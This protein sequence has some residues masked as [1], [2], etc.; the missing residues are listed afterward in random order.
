M[1]ACWL[2]DTCRRCM[3]ETRSVEEPVTRSAPVLQTKPISAVQ[4]AGAGYS[5]PVRLA[6]P[7]G[8]P[9]SPRSPRD[10]DTASCA[11]SVIDALADTSVYDTSAA[12]TPAVP[13]FCP[14][15]RPTSS[16]PEPPPEPAAAAAA[17]APAGAS[18][19]AP[20]RTAEAPSAESASKP[21]AAAPSE[22]LAKVGPATVPWRVVK[23]SSARGPKAKGSPESALR[24]TSF[25]GPPSPP[26]AACGF[27]WIEQGRIGGMG[28]PM[29]PLETLLLSRDL[30]V[31]TIVV[32]TEADE[33]TALVKAA[34]APIKCYH[35]PV[36][37]YMPPTLQQIQMFI[38]FDRQQHF[39][40]G[41]ATAVHCMAGRGRTGVL[42]AAWLCANK[43]MSA[44]EA[45]AAVRARRPRSIETK[46]QE[47]VIIA[48]AAT[49]GPR[50]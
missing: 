5:E 48:F 32:L 28:A 39:A 4:L 23:S 9:R 17:A 31:G 3:A 36:R 29:S 6:S 19:E 26:P 30:G 45:V 35:L 24:S 40:T 44:A 1:M 16:D 8:T 7:R 15:A 46:A 37:D 12:S 21:A 27:S 49:L 25:A 42:L 10:D 11:S 22:L 2:A 47:A 41:R 50:R 43:G 34:G 33:T 38:E 20:P 14:P 18:E 13:R